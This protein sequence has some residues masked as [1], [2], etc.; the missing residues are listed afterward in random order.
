MRS[1]HLVVAA[2]VVAALFS[3]FALAQT[4]RNAE[5]STGLVNT[6]S[7]LATAILGTKRA[8]SSVVRAICQEAYDTAQA[9]LAV[10]ATSVAAGDKDG[11]ATHLETA[12]AA[13]ANIATEG[14]KAVAAVRNRLLEGGHH[15]HAT[16]EIAAKYDPGYVVV[17]KEAKKALLEQATTLGRLAGLLRTGAAGRAEIEAAATQLGAVFGTALK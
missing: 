2:L 12:A 7:E 1:R 8:E 16:P 15:H 10:A 11:A 9:H 14:D 6:Y 17:T 4:L 5:T 3:G 13:A